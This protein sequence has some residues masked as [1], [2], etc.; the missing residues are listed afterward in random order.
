M[1]KERK[2]SKEEVMK[3]I[4]DEIRQNK[5]LYELLEKYDKGE[6]TV[7]TSLSHIS[8]K[9]IDNIG[10]KLVDVIRYN[11]KNCKEAKFAIGYFFL[12]GYN[13]VKGD[14]PE[15][16]SI[17]RKPFLRIVMG[18][19]TT[20]PTKEELVAGY[21][22]KEL[23]KA[24]MLEELQRDLNDE[25]V[26]RV[27]SLRN[28]IADGIVDVRLY[29]KQRLHAKLYLFITNPTAMYESKGV[30]V[31]GSSNFTAEGL[32]KNKEL[33]VL[34]TDSTDINHLDNWFEDLWQNS[35]EFRED[36]IKVID[37]SGVTIKAKRQP[38][39]IIKQ[40]YPP[41]GQ[42]L[43]DPELLF[44]YLVYRWFEGMILE[45]VRKDILLEFQVVGVLNAIKIINYYNGVILADSVGLGKSYMASKIIEE[46]ISGKYPHWL[47]TN[48]KIEKEP[49]VLLI[50][51]PSIIAQWEELLIKSG[52]F[53]KTYV[54]GCIRDYPNDKEYVL[55][56]TNNY[57]SHEKKAKIRFI[58][59]GLFQK[60]R[61]E[62]VKK[63]ADKYD[64]FIIDEAHKYRNSNTNRGKNARLL[65]NKHDGFP[66][67]FILL[68]ATPLNNSI[69]DIYNLIRL[70]TDIA[71]TSFNMKGVNV[72][73]LISEYQKLKREYAKTN[74]KEIKN[75]LLKKADELKTKVLDE[76]MVLRTRK[77][78]MEEF[79][80]ITINN[81]PL[82]FND[83][84]PYSIE[85][86]RFYTKKYEDL[87]RSIGEE[88]YNIVFEYTKLYGVR[89]VV[90]EDTSVDIEID[91]R[92][93]E[94]QRDKDRDKEGED[95]NTTKRYIEIADLFR[96]I[97]GKR[98]E[99]GIYA[100]ET[101]LRRIYEKEKIFHTTLANNYYKIKDENDLACVIK[102]AMDKANV[103]K[104]IE[105]ISE[106]YYVD[107][108]IESNYKNMGW[109]RKAKDIMIEYAE[110]HMQKHRESNPA[111]T[112][113]N[114]YANSTM[115][116][117]SKLMLGLRLLIDNIYS[118][119]KKIEKLLGKLDNMKEK[120]TLGRPLTLEKLP[121][122][123]D[124][125]EL[126]VY[127]YGKDDP[128]LELLKQLLYEPSKRSQDLN[129]IPTLYGK[130]VLI[131]TQYKDTAYYLYH[132]LKEW[133]N[134]EIILHRWL[135][136]NNNNANDNVRI[137]LVTGD[138]DIETK[139]NYIRR[140]APIANRYGEKGIV[141]YVNNSQSYDNEI[142]ILISTD[143]L[144][145]GVNLQDADVV[146][147]Y[148]L[149]WNPMVIVQRVGR[150]NR[151]GNEK[152][153][154]VIN[155]LPS[156]EIDVVV[157]VLQKLKEK[158]DDITL[159]IGK[160]VRILHP[161]EDI[162]IQTFG[163][164]IKS[165]SKKKI[166]ELED[167]MLDD[168]F[169]QFIPQGIPKEQID[170]YKLLNIIQYELNY[171]PEDFEEVKD[172]IKAK[173]GK[174]SSP[175]YTYISKAYND[176]ERIIGIYEF[177][178]GQT[179]IDKKIM[180]INISNNTKTAHDNSTTDTLDDYG[181][182]TG[183]NYKNVNITYETPLI[184]LDLIKNRRSSI[185]N[186]D[187]AIECIKVMQDKCEQIVDNMKQEGVNR[188]KGFLKDLYN[189]LVNERDKVKEINKEEESFEDK[190]YN[191]V[192]I[193]GMLPVQSAREIKNTLTFTNSI[194]ISNNR[195][196]E[197]RVKINDLKAVINTLYEDFQSRGITIPSL[198]PYYVHVGWYYEL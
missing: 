90:F 120:D 127:R 57:D 108:D 126:Y 21:R 97:L 82:I 13:L 119:L 28:L 64:L 103:M 56:T 182:G 33:N 159:I 49:S 66:N 34:I 80:D 123:E 7:N 196:E 18:N 152:D 9:I 186:V 14:F 102:E 69:N 1:L 132:N 84:Q 160:D 142:H 129:D 11:I 170:E 37:I 30:A 121:K 116:E 109:F 156:D 192:N 74:D 163:E 38:T 87:V 183:E 138:T 143:V 134:K 145:E 60:M 65:Q 175:Y 125:I 94:S 190:F 6:Y 147:N 20:Y 71:F 52:N 32:T 180:C 99:S 191:V 44:K 106:E 148:D 189:A 19:E 62:E 104:E 185:S 29:D 70:F 164:R 41:F 92:T 117:F 150:V 162:N 16:S 89:F 68:T 86:K 195:N 72:P 61:E 198:E 128:K 59:L 165:I 130:K 115:N 178:S 118:D 151:I 107:I 2:P 166:T 73:E 27:I 50:L 76:I 140:F 67:K 85:C 168:D 101:T 10:N 40:K 12:T 133:V 100:F 113:S 139:M 197:P 169:K 181:N 43:E 158:I 157:R 111:N 194:T 153:I 25:E 31:V 8:Q 23:F 24:R 161:N 39:T 167:Y 4:E 112:N 179:K 36:L 144:S 46:F 81:K 47:D 131:F 177:Y 114:N 124:I 55:S 75:K 174:G 98:L 193:I 22:L 26:N 105:E 51:P 78:I 176:S 187:K 83:P 42:Y 15:P 63:L 77:Y 154:I 95:I 3:A 171:R 110:D 172:L 136:Y 141:N 79:K 146:I 17:T 45:L 5:Q 96:L 48:N 53:L 184:F 149:P 88:L 173:D 58:S 122:E 35:M 155:Y 135:K 93:K 54:K 188:Q 137:G 91:S